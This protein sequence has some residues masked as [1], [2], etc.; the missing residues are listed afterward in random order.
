MQFYEREKELTDSA[1]AYLAGALIAGEVA[2]AVA[3]PTRIRAFEQAIDEAGIDVAL[4]R[5][6]GALLTL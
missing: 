3:S 6:T 4:A 2:V 5:R 1:G